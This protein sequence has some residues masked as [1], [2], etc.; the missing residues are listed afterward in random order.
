MPKPSK[1]KPAYIKK[2]EW[3]DEEKTPNAVFSGGDY[4]VNC[5]IVRSTIDE[6]DQGPGLHVHPYDE[7]VHIIKG[8]AEFTIG[9]NT[10]IAEEGSIIVGPANLPHS[11]KNKGPGPLEIIDIH[12]SDEWIQYDL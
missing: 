5:V 9:E 3:F 6:V 1:V 8:A 7:I 4:G 11:F 12:L 2:N 10:M